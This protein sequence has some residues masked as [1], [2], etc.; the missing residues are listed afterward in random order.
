MSGPR[1]GVAA[2]TLREAATLREKQDQVEDEDAMEPST[3]S[4]LGIEDMKG[5]PPLLPDLGSPK[6]L[7]LRP[8]DVIVAHP[9]LA[10]RGAL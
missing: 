4:A 3:E 2:K 7:I 9:K 8:G 10:H 5:R 6:Q 1:P